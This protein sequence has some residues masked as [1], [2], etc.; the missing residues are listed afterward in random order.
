[1]LSVTAERTRIAADSDDLAFVE[2]ALTDAAGTTF[3]DADRLVQVAV[4]GPGVLAGLGTGRART[5]E[6][7]G[8]SEVTTYDGRA[9]AIVR[10]TGAGELTVTVS[11]DGLETVGLAVIAG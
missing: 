3:G 1:M 6:S 4:A 5:E 8:A 10:P 9:L 7:F 11:A 2:I